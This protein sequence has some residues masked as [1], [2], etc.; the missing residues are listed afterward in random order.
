MAAIFQYGHHYMCCTIK[1]SN[2]SMELRES[3]KCLIAHHGVCTVQ[4]CIRILTL[5]DSMSTWVHGSTNY[6][7]K[8]QFVYSPSHLLSLIK[9][10][11]YIVLFVPIRS[12]IVFA[13]VNT[14]CLM[15]SNSRICNY[16]MLC[17]RDQGG[18]I[19][20]FRTCIHTWS[21]VDNSLQ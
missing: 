6:V 15:V 8:S 11:T 5:P 13:V 1:W 2:I 17:R 10:V 16:T 4:Q 3:F 14:W 18:N 7:N 12:Y 21:P 9:H 19:Y 20:T